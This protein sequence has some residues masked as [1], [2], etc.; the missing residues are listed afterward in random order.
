MDGL[1]ECFA[2]FQFTHSKVSDQQHTPSTEMTPPAIR[3]IIP[4]KDRAS[5]DFSEETSHK[6]SSKINTSI[7]PV[8]EKLNKDLKV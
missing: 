5:A 1:K 3:V 4:F 6:P 8:F 7:Q 2:S